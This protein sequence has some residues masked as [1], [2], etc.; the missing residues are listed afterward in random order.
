MIFQPPRVLPRILACVRVHDTE[1][2]TYALLDGYP[3]RLSK[4]YQTIVFRDDGTTEIKN[5]TD[6]E[7]EALRSQEH[8]VQDERIQRL[9]Q[10]Q[11]AQMRARQAARSSTIASALVMIERNPR[12]E[13]YDASGSESSEDTGFDLLSVPRDEFG[14]RIALNPTAAAADTLV[15]LQGT[16]A[17][18]STRRWD[19]EV[20]LDDNDSLTSKRMVELS[21]D[22]LRMIL[23][24][25]PA[26]TLR[27][28]QAVDQRTHR[29]AS[30][31]LRN[32]GRRV[33]A[34]KG[35]GRQKAHRE[36]NFARWTWPDGDGPQAP[37]GA[38][39][40]LR[41]AAKALRLT[42]AATV[43][44]DAP[45][46]R[47]ASSSAFGS[48]LRAC[49]PSGGAAAPFDLPLL[50]PPL[51]PLLQADAGVAD[52]LAIPRPPSAAP[53]KSMVPF[54]HISPDRLLISRDPGQQGWTT[55][56][57]DR[58]HSHEVLTVA[59][60]I[61]KLSGPMCV[62]VVGLNY[63]K[64]HARGGDEP[65]L[66]RRRGSAGRSVGAR[67][68]AA[69]DALASAAASWE[70]SSPL[71]RSSHAIVCNAYS[72]R[73]FF[74]GHRHEYLAIPQPRVLKGSAK[75]KGML[76]RDGC[77]LN[78]IVDAK[79]RTLR[80]ELLAQH[81]CMLVPESE[82]EVHGLPAE[83][84]VAVSLGPTT[85]GSAISAGFGGALG[86][87][88]E[89][90]VRLVGSSIDDSD[91][92][93]PGKTIKDLWDVSNVVKPLESAR[94]LRNPDGPGAA[95]VDALAAEYM[96]VLASTAEASGW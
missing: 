37:R 26:T 10:Q 76:L 45:A 59:L 65:V 4:K 90:R 32:I 94:S 49:A 16:A 33:G 95:A 43:T 63:Q 86:S 96:H 9:M 30:E 72:G 71:E 78:V 19:L 55:C 77:R 92:Y 82:L 40:T 34:F 6:I 84:A 20:D 48:A 88:G 18:S 1:V 56:I 42:V 11:E 52:R 69:A 7:T 68:A 12:E 15:P 39:E 89:S 81:G 73:V 79:A 50:A 66:P 25:C 80:F 47:A 21:D 38:V 22:L 36:V 91:V 31:L 44:A 17:A 13:A 54:V 74:K 8:R 2:R 3:L 70:G 29:I 53:D 35:T 27:E 87:G 83:V 23:S 61:E 85:V 24:M 41:A 67:W 93:D 51:P 60:I 14:M 57:V 62:G 64:D 28:A 75:S 46:A 5:S 58:W